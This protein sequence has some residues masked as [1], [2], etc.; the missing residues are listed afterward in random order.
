[1]TARRA[2]GWGAAGV[3]GA[4]AALWLWAEAVDRRSTA[5]E[6][7]AAGDPNGLEAVVVLGYG[8]RGRRANAVNRYR[9]RAALRSFSG[10]S[11]ERLLVL[12]GGSVAGP[13][14]EARVLLDEARRQGYDG[15]VALDEASTTT[16]E[17]VVNAIPLVERADAI[18]IVSNGLHAQKARAYLRRP[19]PDLGARLMPGREHRF[20]EIPVIKVF[21]TLLG[22][23][24]LRRMPSDGAVIP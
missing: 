3:V 17:N 18:R 2:V 9:V 20:G 5:R 21:A 13:V 10:R 11:R 24:A 8:N 7:G 4:C 19:R 12:C 14:S 22:L 6:L 16:Y 15:A 23:A 1:M